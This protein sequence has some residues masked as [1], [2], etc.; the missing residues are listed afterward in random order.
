LVH[1]E[2]HHDGSCC[3]AAA[4][5]GWHRASLADKHVLVPGAVES[6]A[7]D[8]VSLAAATLRATGATASA[9]LRVQLVSGDDRPW[10]ALEYQRTGPM[11]FGDPEQPIWSRTVRRPLPVQWELSPRA[12]D[13]EIRAGAR[14]IALDVTNQF[15]IQELTVLP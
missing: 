7:V 4:T 6:V 13:D 8:F 1:V 11:R 10:A 14:Q 9:G 12:G 3:L 2:V 15:G 5:E